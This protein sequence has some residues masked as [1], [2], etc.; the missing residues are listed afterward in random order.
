MVGPRNTDVKRRIDQEEGGK[1]RRTALIVSS[2]LDRNRDRSLAFIGAGPPVIAPPCDAN[3][4]FASAP[5]GA[6][7]SAGRRVEDESRAPRPRGEKRPANVTRMS[8]KVMHIATGEEEEALRDFGE[9]GGET[10]VG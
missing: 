9:I 5:G 1:A 2:S 3:R 6:G 10:M 4:H 7:S 8:A